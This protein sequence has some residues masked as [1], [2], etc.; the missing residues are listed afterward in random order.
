M[1]R[2][3]TRQ[4]LWG[5]A[6]ISPW[7]IGLLLFTA[8]P[9]VAVF[10]WGFT[11]YPILSEPRW[12][13]LAN[14]QKIFQ[15]DPLFWKSLYNTAYY[16]GI[17][18]PIHLGLAFALALLINHAIRGISLF[19][20]AIYLP[21]VVPVVALAV[22]WR[23]LLDPRSGYLN[24][25]GGFIGLPEVNWL[26]SEAWIKPAIIGISLFQ[27]GI[28]MVIFLAGLQSIPEQLYE[29]AA[30]DGANS[31]QRLVNVTVPLLTPVILYNL[32]VDIIN[33][34]QV[35]AYAYVLTKGGPADAA[36]FYVVY[37]YRHAF[38]L[39]Q[40]G[41]AAALSAILFVIILIFTVILMSFSD[42]WVQ[43]ER[44]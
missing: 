15:G 41:Y 17:R 16:V 27:V 38:E 31:W 7:L 20:T 13:G 33:S 8:W 43:Y 42:R 5:Y 10:Y 34:F 2:L 18:V 19:R 30:I 25:Y 32:V 4:A 21:S 6:F 36:M 28:A 24:Y 44:I 3:S 1:M 39:F 29:A 14:Y 40:M 9:I 11:E 26:T 12:V 23:L 37:I 22:I 35:F